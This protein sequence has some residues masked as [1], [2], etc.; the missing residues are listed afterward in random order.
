MEA[1]W[2]KLLHMILPARPANRRNNGFSELLLNKFYD[3]QMFL[4]DHIDHPMNFL[5]AMPNYHFKK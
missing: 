1:N 2:R 3:L 5:H 4:T